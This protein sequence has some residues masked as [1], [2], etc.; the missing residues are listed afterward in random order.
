[1]SGKQKQV[2]FLLLPLHVA[3]DIELKSLS[4]RAHPPLTTR[5]TMSNRLVFVVTLINH[6]HRIALILLSRHCS[7]C[8][9]RTSPLISWAIRPMPRQG[10]WNHTIRVHKSDW[11]TKGSR[12]AFHYSLNF[13]SGCVG[14]IL[15][16]K[17]TARWICVATRTLRLE[18]LGTYRCVNRC[19]HRQ[20]TCLHARV[21]HQALA[22]SA[23]DAAAG[24]R[25]GFRGEPRLPGPSFWT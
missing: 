11:M 21:G 9:R 14:C 24:E 8:G 4:Y 7:K 25:H 16:D 1:M 19:I 20:D 5:T 18:L 2:V 22:D 15:V 3:S 6:M 10:A 13:Q 17:D 23:G 12:E